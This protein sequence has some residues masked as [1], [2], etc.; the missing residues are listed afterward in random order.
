MAQNYS[1]SFS[2]SVASSVGNDYCSLFIPKCPTNPVL[3]RHE[4]RADKTS[5]RFVIF[6][7]G[8]ADERTV[9]E[10]LQGCL[11]DEL[12]GAII[13]IK[14]VT[15]MS[16][17]PRMDLWT[18]PELGEVL[19]R[20]ITE[21]RKE[22]NTPNL[23]SVLKRCLNYW[24]RRSKFPWSWRVDVYRPWRDR[25]RT[26]AVVDEPTRDD[27]TAM[28]TWNINGF[29]SKEEVVKQAL[30]TQ[31]VAICVLQETLVSDTSKPI[32]VDGYSVFCEPRRTGFR[33]MAVLVDNR[34]PAYRIPHEE[35]WL[36]HVKVSHWRHAKE[37]HVG[38]HILGVYFPSGGNYKG[39][40]T[41]KLKELSKLSKELAA[42][43]PRDLIVALGDLNM[44]F[45]GVAKRMS[46][47]NAAIHGLETVGS[48]LSCFPI[49]GKPADLDHMLGNLPVHRWFRKPRVMR[50]YAVSD[51]RPVILVSRERV[52]DEVGPSSRAVFSK[53]MVNRHKQTLVNCNRWE[54][55]LA[56]VESSESDNE[57]ARG[58]GLNAVT[59]VFNKVFDEECR[60]LDI[61][62]DLKDNAPKNK[63]PRKVA[64]LLKKVKRTSEKLEAGRDGPTED[65]LQVELARNKKRYKKAHSK[66]RQQERQK[67][68]D[69]IARDMATFDFKSAWTRVKAE[70]NLLNS[71]GENEP[72]KPSQPLRDKRGVL[73]TKPEELQKVMADHYKE[74]LQDD[75]TGEMRS[76]DFW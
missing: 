70:A 41:V 19:K 71:T 44:P 45:E 16:G 5:V 40:R 17:A 58:L 51:H 21:S 2:E 10:W 18:R 6:N 30:F 1:R 43:N 24:N 34:L 53:Q 32:R 56:L 38:I 22:D 49:R 63:I 9:W 61:K 73:R 57:E 74:L 23:R 12:L 33:G 68:Y 25:A 37:A 60:Q 76:Y 67:S 62:R 31:K 20:N 75:A 66:W 65:R 14:K 59:D 3:K 72:M 35:P 42:K 47:Y 36:I 11:T 27:Y 13:S 50:S 8:D 28:M 7:T 26:P 29:H 64:T 54:P 69:R 39:K 15:H 46:K 55:L 52:P 4:L 48:R